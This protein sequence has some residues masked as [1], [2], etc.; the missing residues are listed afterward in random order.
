MKILLSLSVHCVLG[1]RV[2]VTI[3][4]HDLGVAKRAIDDDRLMHHT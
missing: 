4:G 2:R 1:L 3:H